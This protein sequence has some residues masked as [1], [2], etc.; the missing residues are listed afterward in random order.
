MLKIETYLARDSYG[1]VG[2]FAGE[3]VRSGQII[4]EW[5]DEVE[6]TFTRQ[7]YESLPQ[8]FRRYVEKHGYSP[9][10]KTIVLNLDDSKFFNHS[11]EPNT[12]EDLEG[13]IRVM[14]NIRKGTELTCDYTLFDCQREFCSSFLKEMNS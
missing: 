9:D 13:K 11:F 5:R 2:L 12:L 1:G 6:R 10:G 8:E 3:D 7:E 14:Q 4:W